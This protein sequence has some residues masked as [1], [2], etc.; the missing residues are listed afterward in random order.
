M[1]SP[2]APVRPALH[3]LLAYRLLGVRVPYQNRYWVRD[4]VLR[5]GFA[6]R[7]ALVLFP[8]IFVVYGVLIPFGVAVAM[9]L[10]Y[11]EFEY[12]GPPIWWPVTVP[13][14]MVLLETALDRLFPRLFG[15]RRRSMLRRHDFHPDGSPIAYPPFWIPYPPMPPR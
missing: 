13:V 5:P 3:R 14:G 8:V 4:D 10:Q 6:T 7:Q 9:F 2:T 11:G 1:Y 12:L 15:Y